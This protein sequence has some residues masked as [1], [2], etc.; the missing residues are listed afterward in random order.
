MKR[1][2]FIKIIS[3]SGAVLT[4]PNPVEACEQASNLHSPDDIRLKVLAYA[5]LAPNAHNIQPWRIKLGES[6]GLELYVDPARLLPETDPPARQIHISQGT[7]LENLDIAAREF[8]YSVKINY[9]PQGMY[10]NDVLEDKAVAHVSLQRQKVQQESQLFPYLTQRQSNKRV[11]DK[12]P[13]ETSVLQ[14]LRSLEI[15]KGMALHIEDEPQRVKQIAAFC[16]Q[17]MAIENQS[18]AREMETIHMFRFTD[19]EARAK[20]DGLTVA[21]TGKTGFSKWL[22]EAF[23]ISRHKAEA[24]PQQFSDEGTALAKQQAESAAA[25]AW[26]TTE[27]N[28]RI[29]QVLCGRFYEYLHLHTSALNL[30]QHPMSQILQ[31]YPDMRQLQ[32]EFKHFIGL[33]EGHTVQMLMRLGYAAPVP[34]TMR[35]KPMALL[36]D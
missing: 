14:R 6:L 35:R 8:G 25:F 9:F 4:L 12:R 27:N 15:P 11:Y 31:E 32:S 18:Q 20:C 5:C 2:D 22:V 30:A 36:T 26:I 7:F 17:A 16:A 23:F 29:D 10:G 3:A 21:Q 33:S 34:Y 19:D 28:Q 13:I 1:R 24:D